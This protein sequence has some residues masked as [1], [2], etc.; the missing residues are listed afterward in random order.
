MEAPVTIVV[1]GAGAIG[2]LV[3]GRTA[4]S[5]QRTVLLARPRVGE[6]IAQHG[7]RVLEDGTLHIAEGLVT[8]ADAAELPAE[9]RNPELA[10]LS[11]KGYDTEGALPT[12]AALNPQFIMTL[13]NGLGNEELL[14]ERFGAARILSGAITIPVEIEAPGRIAVARRGGIGIAPMRPSGR[15]AAAWAASALRRAAFEV[16][17]FADYRA[18]K[19]SKALLNILGNAT[20]AIL[21]QPLSEVFADK[22]MV[23]LERRAFL[24]A[25]AV[26]DRRGIRPVNLP[27]HAVATL[28]TAVRRMPPAVIDPLLR[29]LIAGGR[30][31]K[32][33]SLHLDLARGN[34]RSEGAF[35]YGAI[36]HAA[37][38]AGVDAPVNHALWE[39]LQ[40]IV[41]GEVPW[42]E[43]RRQPERLLETIEEQPVVRG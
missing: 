42:D 13:Q 39:I 22:R 26:M 27:R 2:L 16:R 10:I 30:G 21:D 40:A 11:V 24:E 31:N 38:E 32:P 9:D 7:L 6:A 25:L 41:S 33:P 28:A 8:I 29:R 18:L 20:A 43:F 17:E 1:V 3:A 4:R 34:P 12:L 15:Q 37:D 5:S 19:W 23:D 36:A 14:A 35:L